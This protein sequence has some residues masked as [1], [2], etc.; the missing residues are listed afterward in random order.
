MASVIWHAY[1]QIKSTDQMK[2]FRSHNPAFKDGEQMRDF[3]FVKDVVDVCIWLM[4]HRKNS[5]IYNL[6]SGKARTFN[7]LVAAVFKE[8]ELPKNIAYIDTPED[9][10]SKYQYFTEAKMDK[11]RSIGYSKPFT[12]LEDGVSSYVKYLNRG[13]YY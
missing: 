12:N 4:Q 1:N 6:G 5:G 13:S 2:L 3:I 11:L 8:L 9:I 7:D 10:R